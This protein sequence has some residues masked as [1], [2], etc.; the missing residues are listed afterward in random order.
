[1]RL[2]VAASHGTAFA[3]ITA[4]VPTVSVMHEQVHQRTCRQEQPR[5]GTE[6]M[7]RMLGNQK[8]SRDSQKAAEDDP[9]RGSP[10]RRLSLLVHHFVPFLLSLGHQVDN[11]ANA[12]HRQ[13]TAKKL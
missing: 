9:K 2:V 3:A 12:D 1:M 11:R 8:K 4:S 7:R 13:R 5:Q 6:D 10:P